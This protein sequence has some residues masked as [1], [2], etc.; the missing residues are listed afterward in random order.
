LS[1]PEENRLAPHRRFDAAA[2]DYSR[3]RPADPAEIGRWLVETAALA[4]GAPALDLAAGTG[5]MTVPLAD[6]GLAVTAVEP[7]APMRAVLAERAPSADVVDALAESL[8]FPD[9]GFRLVTVANAWHWFQPETAYPEIRRVLA[10][11]G[12]LAVIWNVED[13]ADELSRRVDDLKLTV[14]DRSAVPGPH[15][16]Q[17]LGWDREFVTAERAEFHHVHRPPGVVEYVSSW[18]FVA[19][20]PADERERFL[21]GI[22]AWAPAGPVDLPFRVTVTLGRPRRDPA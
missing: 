9:A 7:S 22:R 4:P 13:R 1:A 8:P 5:A 10:P 14:L 17:P 11:D 16:E 6:A 2:S 19:N 20:M 18:S 15:E 12:R 21:D 3:G